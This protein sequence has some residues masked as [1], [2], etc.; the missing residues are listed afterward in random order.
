[1]TR[2]LKPWQA[3]GIG[4]G[5]LLI[6]GVIGV[7]MWMISPWL[8]YGMVVFFVAVFSYGIYKNRHIFK[9]E[10]KPQSGQKPNQEKPNEKN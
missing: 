3:Y 1:V 5:L 10:E 4:I 2:K 9:V 8:I 7:F 6:A